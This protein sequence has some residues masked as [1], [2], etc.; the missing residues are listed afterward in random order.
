MP[1]NSHNN[2]AVSQLSPFVQ[3]MAL[4]KIDRMLSM[5][6]LHHCTRDKQISY[7][8]ILMNLLMSMVQ[9]RSVLIVSVLNGRCSP[10]V[11]SAAVVSI[12]VDCFRF[13]VD[14][15]ATSMS[16][17]IQFARW[18]WQMRLEFVSRCT[19]ERNQMMA[20]AFGLAFP[21]NAPLFRRA[22]CVSGST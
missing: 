11:S 6:A 13:Q 7:P 10:F 21:P 5:D 4:L 19:F 2:V 9:Q 15:R 22:I 3:P 1:N 8:L 14:Y 16:H 17:S 18:R 12:D 20:A